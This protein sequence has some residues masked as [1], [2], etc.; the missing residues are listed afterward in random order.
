VADPSPQLELLPEH[1]VAADV[2]KGGRRLAQMHGA[3]GPGPE[4]AR[5][6]GCRFFERRGGRSNRR[7]F[8]CLR[9]VVTASKATDWKA[10]WPACGLYTPKGS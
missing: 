2:P 1:A 9:T 10:L 6:R 5:C 7:W 8:K 4:G 3:Y